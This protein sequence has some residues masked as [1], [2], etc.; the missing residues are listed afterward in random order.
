MDKPKIEVRAG[1]RQDLGVPHRLHLSADEVSAPT[2]AVGAGPTVQVAN[3]F[4]GAPIIDAAAG[5]RMSLLLDGAGKARLRGHSF[6][7]YRWH[8]PT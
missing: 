1:Y 6:S 7:S 3:V 5:G 2:G 8:S 4:S